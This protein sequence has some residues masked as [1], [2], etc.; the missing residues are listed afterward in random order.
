[1]ALLIVWQYHLE[2]SQLSICLLLLFQCICPSPF[3]LAVQTATSVHLV[4]RR[5][6]PL[7][8]C[9]L[10]FLLLPL[11]TSVSIYF[12]LSMDSLSHVTSLTA[13]FYLC[14]AFERLNLAALE[15]YRHW[16][17]IESS[18]RLTFWRHLW[19]VLL[20]VIVD[21]VLCSVM[22]ALWLFIG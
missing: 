21:M 6:F 16:H 20:S 13:G 15:T 7:S 8:H 19:A 12:S 14:H 18:K 9:F 5:W 1:M 2:S 10:S 3:F 17:T 22:G 4:M 11:W